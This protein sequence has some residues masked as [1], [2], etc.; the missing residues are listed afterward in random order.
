MKTFRL[1]DEADHLRLLALLDPDS[2]P[3]LSAAQATALSAFLEETSITRDAAELECR[4]S[5]YDRI[6]L[7]SPTDSRDW[8]KPEIVMPQEA[9]IDLDRISALTPMGLAVLGRRTGDRVT[10]ETAAGMRLMTITAVLKEAIP[11]S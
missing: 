2:L 3:R 7:V 1:L 8:Y 6:T 11:A 10:W 4:I 5:L 9:D